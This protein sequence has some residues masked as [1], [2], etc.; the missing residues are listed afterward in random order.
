[1]SNE[2]YL[3]YR[4]PFTDEYYATKAEQQSS[5]KEFRQP[6]IDTRQEYVESKESYERDYV[7][8]TNFENQLASY[9]HLI[10]SCKDSLNDINSISNLAFSLFDKNPNLSV[11]GLEVVDN[12]EL[13]SEIGIFDGILSDKQTVFDNCGKSLD[14]TKKVIAD[15]VANLVS[16]IKQKDREIQDINQYI[17]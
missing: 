4:N 6:Y 10:D 13:K 14:N 1:M 5:L 15:K 3:P 17:D 9:R 8:I 2:D 7:T 11:D 12:T 16:L